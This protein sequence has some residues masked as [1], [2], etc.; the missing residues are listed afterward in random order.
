MY[1]EWQHVLSQNDLFLTRFTLSISW[2][3]FRLLEVSPGAA[4]RPE[5]RASV[6]VGLWWFAQI[7][8]MWSVE[9]DSYLISFINI[10]CQSMI[11]SGWKKKGLQEY[12]SVGIVLWGVIRLVCV[13]EFLVGFRVFLTCVFIHVYLNGVKGSL[14]GYYLMEIWG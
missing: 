4:P 7:W 14:Y 1:S 12:G 6:S 8:V 10:L 13:N 3:C 5:I 2:R 11:F 9:R